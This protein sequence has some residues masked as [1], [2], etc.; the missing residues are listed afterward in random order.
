MKDK[1]NEQ[2]AE[3]KV[4]SVY[5]Q[6]TG[7]LAQLFDCNFQCIETDGDPGIEQSICTLCSRGVLGCR[8][9]HMQAMQESG[10]NGN[11]H[12]YKCE[13]GLLFWV[14]PIYNEGKFAGAMRGSGFLDGSQNVS[15]I[16]KKCR[17]MRGAHITPEQFA[18]AV[19]AF[20]FGNAEKIQSLAEILLLCAESLSTGAG[21]SHEELRIRF[22]QKASLTALVEKMK[23]AHPPGA[24]LPGY[25]HDKERQLI[26]VL[27]RGNKAE[28]DKLLDELLASLMFTNCQQGAENK[29]ALS[30]SAHFRHIQFRAIE[31]AVLLTRAGLHASSNASMENNARD[32]KLIQEARS[33]EE[34]AF[35]LHGIIDR[36][37]LQIISFQGLPHAAAMRKAESFIRENLTRRISLKEIAAVAGLS[38]PYFS[39]I[40]KEE[41]GENL[42]RYVNRLRVEKASRLLLETS[43]T[44]SDIAGECCFEDQ[45]WFSKIFKSFTGISP[46]K[47]RSQ[48]GSMITGACE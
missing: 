46:G 14:S 32:I 37:S 34:L 10:R 23:A 35:I 5:K 17:V 6:S 29:Q 27:R 12:I 48:G 25:P 36:V 31:L 28:S 42:S 20:P 18:N 8:E 21:N 15:Q 11:A 44:L 24:E 19:L 43:L 22:E 47:F 13:L 7:S 33:I 2:S 16:M 40:F 41:M 30:E 9:M 38:A 26:A 39:T 1:K 45:S 3:S 4:V